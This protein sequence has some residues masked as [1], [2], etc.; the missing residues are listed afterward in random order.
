MH[1]S[2]EVY[3]DMARNELVLHRNDPIVGEGRCGEPRWIG[4]RRFLHVWYTY[5]IFLSY[6]TDKIMK[7]LVAAKTVTRRRTNKSVLYERART[8]Y[9]EHATGMFF[10][11]ASNKNAEKKGAA[12][13]LRPF[14]GT[15]TTAWPE[16][17]AKHGLV[18]AEIVCVEGLPVSIRIDGDAFSVTTDSWPSMEGFLGLNELWK[19]ERYRPDWDTIFDERRSA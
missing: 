16:Y 2:K 11:P 9:Y 4:E 17:Q 1:T 12:Y 8:V 7:E 10:I 13:E 5:G 19:P 14:H 3:T 15:I 18:D 6:A